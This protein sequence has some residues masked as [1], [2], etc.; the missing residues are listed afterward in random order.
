MISKKDF[1]WFVAC[2]F[3]AG[4]CLGRVVEQE[5]NATLGLIGT[6]IV[7]V[8]TYAAYITSFPTEEEL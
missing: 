1:R 4:W 2:A 7:L 6:I 3:A 8:V 5:G